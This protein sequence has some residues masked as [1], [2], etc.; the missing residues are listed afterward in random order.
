L[1]AL[2]H[3]VPEASRFAYTSSSFNCD[4]TV[5]HMH[6]VDVALVVLVPALF[7]LGYGLTKTRRGMLE[8]AQWAGIGAGAVAAVIALACELLLGLAMPLRSMPPI[9]ASVAQAF[10]MAAIPEEWFKLGALLYVIRRQKGLDDAAGMIMTGL[11]VG[12][13][14]AVIEDAIYVEAAGHRSALGGGVVATLRAVSAVPMHAVWGM[15]MASLM[16]G[17][18]T[19]QQ[20][21]ESQCRRRLVLALMVPI[22]LHGIYDFLFMLSVRHPHDAWT[23]RLVSP[24]IA[25]SVGLAIILCNR[26]LPRASRFD[27]RA[28]S[29]AASPA[30]L[31]IILLTV[32]FTF[33]LIM[34]R[35]ANLLLAQTMAIFCVVPLMLGIDLVWTALSRMRN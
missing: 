8:A 9:A 20:F 1:R 12:L 18:V 10:M 15:T 27:E 23:I 3:V 35:L 26:A 22:M 6:L 28:R 19:I 25:L 13:G 30:V 11:A 31:G 21:G 4:N 24:T 5:S 16:I 7:L 34:L 32:G 17:A 33:V 2:Q 14:F 29:S